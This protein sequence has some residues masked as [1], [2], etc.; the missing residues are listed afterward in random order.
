[1]IDYINYSNLLLLVCKMFAK[2]LP[3]K[4]MKKR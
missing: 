3:V 2:L 4:A 1:M